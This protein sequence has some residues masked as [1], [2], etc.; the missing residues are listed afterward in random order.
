[1]RLVL[2]GLLAGL[3]TLAIFPMVMTVGRKLKE[4]LLAMFEKDE[5]EPEPEEE[6]KE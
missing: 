6:E 5:P 3:A 2:L 1:M 4:Y